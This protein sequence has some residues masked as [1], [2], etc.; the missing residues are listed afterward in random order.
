MFSGTKV[1]LPPSFAILLLVCCC[2]AAL[3]RVPRPVV[4]VALACDSLV[5]AVILRRSAQQDS[6]VKPAV[7]DALYKYYQNYIN[8]SC[9]CQIISSV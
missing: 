3:F 2:A 6:T 1:C 5:Q 7:M 8:V 4:G 9:V